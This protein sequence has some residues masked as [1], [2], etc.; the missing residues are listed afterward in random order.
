M[1]Y[2]LLINNGIILGIVEENSPYSLTIDTIQLVN[3]FNLFKIGEKFTTNTLKHKLLERDT[4]STILNDLKVCEEYLQKECRYSCTMYNA[5]TKQEIANL[6]NYQEGEIKVLNGE[7]LELYE[8][9]VNV[10]YG[11]SLDINTREILDIYEKTDD[12]VIKNREVQT[13]KGGYNSK[14]KQ[15][16]LATTVAEVL[17]IN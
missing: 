9:N 1:N 16:E 14:L 10:H 6:F 11:V 12:G 4:Y 8:Y 17:V 13:I 15:L 3:D 5:T 2:L 7:L